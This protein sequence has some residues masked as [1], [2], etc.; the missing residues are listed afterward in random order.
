MEHEVKFLD[1]EIPRVRRLLSQHDATMIFD[2]V[3]ETMYLDKPD[4]HFENIGKSI[5]V[6][7]KGDRTFITTKKRLQNAHNIKVCEE[8]ETEVQSLEETLRIF[9]I[10]GLSVYRRIVKHRESFRLSLGQVE[11]DT[12]LNTEPKIK[13]YVELETESENEL[14]A[15]AKLLK[16]PMREA[17]DWSTG[18]VI[19]NSGAR[20]L[21]VRETRHHMRSFLNSAT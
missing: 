8:D 9:E 19:R 16:L 20:L 11:I 1:A 18:K 2:D 10:L 3:M 6:R 14:Q 15:L 21:S 4:R 13:P 5:R 17:K 7:K 12:I